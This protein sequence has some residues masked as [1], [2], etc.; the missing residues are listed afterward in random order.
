MEMFNTFNV[1][2]I[3]G[4]KDLKYIIQFNITKQNKSERL[5]L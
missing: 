4:Y 1:K 3:Y 2:N 5:K